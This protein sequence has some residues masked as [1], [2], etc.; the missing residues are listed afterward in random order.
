MVG[1][2]G[3]DFDWPRRA[4][5]WV[6]LGLAPSEFAPDNYF[7]ENFFVVARARPD[8]SPSKAEAFVQVLTERLIAAHPEEHLCQGF[9]LGNVRHSLHGVRRR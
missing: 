6:P 1:V 8:V 3:P 7:N 4:D 2:M 9:R 5:V